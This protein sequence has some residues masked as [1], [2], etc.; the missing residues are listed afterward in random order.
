MQGA[1]RPDPVVAEVVGEDIHHPHGDQ[2]RG[3]RAEGL[4]EGGVEDPAQKRHGHI[5][6][7]QRDGHLEAEALLQDQ[8][9]QHVAA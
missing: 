9:E 3:E 1:L 7:E 4:G 2:G 8:R 6:D 5:D